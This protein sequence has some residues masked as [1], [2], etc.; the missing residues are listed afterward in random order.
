MKKLTIATR[1]SKLALWQAN[2]IK[3]ELSKLDENVEIELK[4]LVTR[5]DKVQDRPLALV[6]GK[7]LFTKEIDE[8]MLRGEAQIAVHSMKDLPVVLPEELQLC[9]F[10]ER[11]DVRDALLSEKYDGLDALPKGATVGTTSLRRRMNLYAERPDLNIV[12]L[13]GNVDTRIRKLKEGEYDAIVLA[14]AGINRL[15]LNESVKYFSPIEVTFSIPSM[16]QGALALQ[17]I[18]D[19]YVVDLVSKLNDEV[20]MMEVTIERDFVAKLEGGCQVPIGVSA[21]VLGNGDILVKSLVGLPNGTELLRQSEVV[22]EAEYK[23]AGA[24]LAQ[25]MIDRGAKEVLAKA[26]EIAYK[27]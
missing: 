13:R 20:S 6:G 7:G 18:K 26:S 14:A 21:T 27:D 23:T 1:G 2:H 16:G 22:K 11:E 4:I 17:T 8:A 15:G 9:A 19:P 3:D 5:G 25:D 12:E 10:T 24:R